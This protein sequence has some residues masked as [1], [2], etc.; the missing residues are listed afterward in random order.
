MIQSMSAPQTPGQPAPRAAQPIGAMV[1]AAAAPVLD[2]HA[3]TGEQPGVFGAQMARAA[4]AEQLPPVDLPALPFGAL[5][6]ATT[7]E[8]TSGLPAREAASATE[9]TSLELTAEQWLLGMLGQQQTQVQARDAGQPAAPVATVAI[10]LAATAA[11]PPT[12]TDPLPVSAATLPPTEPPV[13]RGVDAAPTVVETRLP[14]SRAGAEPQPAPSAAPLLEAGA[15]VA[16]R[17]ADPV[18][19]LLGVDDAA[20]GEPASTAGERPAQ[21]PQLGSERLL[22]LQTPQARWGEQMLQALRDNVELQLQQKIQSATIRLDPPELGAL[23]IHLSHESGRLNV[24]LSAAHADV[25]RL[26]QQT[27]DRLRQ[28]L[29]GQNFVQVNVQVGADGQGQQGRGQ[30]R[31]P[32]AEDQ[33]LPAANAQQPATQARGRER[34]AD[35]LVTV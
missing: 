2:G 29:V 34:A 20:R 12:T 11:P 28:E 22:K 15:E 16:Q 8:A 10:A 26:L 14:P 35:V 25:A 21:S 6:V 19:A 1:V 33:P 7:D 3:A 17:V 5:P 32:L 27:S 9:E 24:Q 18:D 31:A 30:P 13:R 23:E 4:D